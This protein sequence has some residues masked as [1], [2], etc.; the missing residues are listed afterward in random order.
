[1]VDPLQHTLG[2]RGFCAQTILQSWDAVVAVAPRAKPAFL[3]AFRAV[4]G[5]FNGLIRHPSG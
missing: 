2:D 3:L 4:A 1:L 5:V